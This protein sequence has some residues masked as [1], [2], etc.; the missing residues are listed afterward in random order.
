MHQPDRPGVLPPRDARHAGAVQAMMIRAR[1]IALG[2]MAAVSSMTAHAARA[3][4]APRRGVDS[5]PGRIVRASPIPADSARRGCLA[6]GDS[7]WG[8]EVKEA[9]PCR[10]RG[11]API[12][13]AATREWSYGQY[14]RVWL[15]PGDHNAPADTVRETEIVLFTANLGSADT[16]RGGVRLLT[17]VWHAFYEP[18][19]IAE[20]RPEVAPQP[21]GDA[22]IA[23]RTCVNG[24]GGCWQDFAI[25]R[26]GRWR[27]VH[28]AFLDSL[29][30]R[31]PGAI[32]HGFAVDPRTLRADAAVYADN[33]ANCC[34][35]RD[36]R[37]RLRLRG[38]SLSIV[39]LR[40]GSPQ[41]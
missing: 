5:L 17:P 26:A 2:A 18:E 4:S 8:P 23:I 1:W 28:L 39:S 29:E 41:E 19:E 3:Q 20:M 11:V 36:A 35:S 7:T 9:A 15:L 22:L 38:D 27:I 30:R 25:F 10:S 24:T 32:R 37:M 12:G 16:S 21:N 13:R 31:F 33:D 14:A 34:P 40:L 6:L